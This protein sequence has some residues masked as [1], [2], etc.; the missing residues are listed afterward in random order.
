M[1]VSGKIWVVLHRISNLAEEQG[2]RFG[3]APDTWPGALLK[4][5]LLHLS[6]VYC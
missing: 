2:S 3:L 4:L 6:L 1:M 5:T